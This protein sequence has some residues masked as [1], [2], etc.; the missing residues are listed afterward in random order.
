MIYPKGPVQLETEGAS[1][2]RCFIRQLRSGQLAV[3]YMASK[4][5]GRD[6]RNHPWIGGELEE[7]IDYIDPVDI[8]RLIKLGE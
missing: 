1:Y 8:Q 5:S 6:K 7:R 2:T 4:D 3:A